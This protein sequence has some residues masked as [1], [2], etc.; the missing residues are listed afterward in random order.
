ML[1]KILKLRIEER[2]TGEEAQEGAEEED[3]ED[4]P[5]TA[6]QYVLDEIKEDEEREITK[7]L[8]KF[9][10]EKRAKER[11]EDIE[12]GDFEE[13]DMVLNDADLAE[14]EKL[15]IEEHGLHLNEIEDE[16]E[17]ITAWAEWVK[18]KI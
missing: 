2:G 10:N 13:D 18:T 4:K 17:Y 1:K 8:F 5:K 12:D 14:I 9:V 7:E 3:D 15:F 11:A 16:E 6:E